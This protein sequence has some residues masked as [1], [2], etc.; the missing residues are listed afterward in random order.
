MRK[1]VIVQKSIMQGKYE[2]QLDSDCYFE[3]DSNIMQVSKM[4]N[5]ECSAD[6]VVTRKGLKKK[7][8]VNELIPYKIYNER[9]K[10]YMIVTRE[11][12]RYEVLS[13][14]DAK[15]KMYLEAM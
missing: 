12:I 5:K 15:V 7:T 1:Y 10:E 4:Y 14:D 2:D 9:V 3:A 11:I 13:T 6:A 8:E